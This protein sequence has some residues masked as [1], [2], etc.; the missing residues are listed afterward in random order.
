MKS[1]KE[2][3]TEK[4]MKKIGEIREKNFEETLGKILNPKKS[5]VI[6]LGTQTSCLFFSFC[7]GALHNL[8]KLA[9]IH[10]NLFVFRRGG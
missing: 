9:W 7:L 6:L 1:M 3:K 2:K 8:Q 5:L 4:I 10:C